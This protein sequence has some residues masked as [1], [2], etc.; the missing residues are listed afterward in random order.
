MPAKLSLTV[1]TL[2]DMVEVTP[3]AGTMSP[4]HQ[5]SWPKSYKPAF[6]DALLGAG[7]QVNQNIDH[8]KENKGRRTDNCAD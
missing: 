2:G 4:S 6:S 7:G 3:L 8:A 5:A 1:A